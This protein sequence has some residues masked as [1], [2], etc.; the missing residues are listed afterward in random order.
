MMLQDLPGRA[1]AALAEWQLRPVDFEV[2]SRI[3]RQP[4]PEGA[5]ILGIYGK[6][7][8]QK[9]TFDLLDAVEKMAPGTTSFRLLMAAGGRYPA[10]SALTERLAASELLAGIVHVIPFLPP[11]QVPRLIDAC[12]AVAFLER[13][14][15]VEIHSP[16]VPVEVLWRGTPLICSEEIVAKQAFRR[17][18]LPWVNFVPAGDPRDTTALANVLGRVIAAPNLRALGRA[19]ARVART[20]F[21]GPRPRDNLVQTLRRN[22]LLTVEEIHPGRR[23]K[24]SRRR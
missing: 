2:L 14:F 23:G 5:F 18:L 20:F 24:I 9:G 15:A 4:I 1:T 16:Q 12:N 11:W 6:L 10:I 7:G 22:D 3:W 8:R 21:R 17:A 19:G 13:G